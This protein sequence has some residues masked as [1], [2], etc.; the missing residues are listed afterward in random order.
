MIFGAFGLPVALPAASA[1]GR[2]S[3]RDLNITSSPQVRC[4]NAQRCPRGAQA[5]Q[6]PERVRG[7]GTELM[8]REGFFRET[9]QVV[10]AGTIGRA[11]DHAF[12]RG[13]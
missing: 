10:S 6:R 4:V 1:A 8:L 9:A 7:K 3:P 13:T 12:A 2:S 5:A 11:A